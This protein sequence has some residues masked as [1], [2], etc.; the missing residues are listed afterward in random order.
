MIPKLVLEPHEGFRVSID[1]FR[2][3]DKNI[4]LKNTDVSIFEITNRASILE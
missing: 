4:A 1:I 2:P 3:T